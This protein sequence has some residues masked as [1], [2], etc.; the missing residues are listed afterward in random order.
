MVDGYRETTFSGHSRTV[1][2]EPTTVVTPCTSP[3]QAQVKNQHGEERWAET[4]LVTG[5]C[6]ESEKLVFS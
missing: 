1:A 3:V 6:K 2:F 5:S 4:K